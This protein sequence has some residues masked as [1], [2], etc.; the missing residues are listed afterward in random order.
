M[1][2]TY[3]CKEDS[4][5]AFALLYAILD[6]GGINAFILYKLNVGDT[7]RVGYLKVV[8]YEL[9]LD[10]IKKRLLNETIPRTFRRKIS[11]FLGEEEGTVLRQ[12][13][14]ERLTQSCA[15]CDWR[16]HRKATAY[17][18]LCEQN[19]YAERIKIKLLCVLIALKMLMMEI[20]QK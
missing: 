16:A 1:P 8:T 5:R 4:Q 18:N 19:P 17:C 6:A 3:H 20:Y 10:H 7:N 9:V 15:I 13:T 14:S 12:S 2:L 11:R